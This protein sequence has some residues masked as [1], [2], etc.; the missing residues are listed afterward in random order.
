VDWL[1]ET[2]WANYPFTDEMSIEIGWFYG[3]STVWPEKGEKWHDDCV[4]VKNKRGNVVMCWGMISWNW[5]GLFWV[6]EQQ[7]EEEK[8]N[9]MKAIKVYNINCTVEEKHLNDLWKLSVE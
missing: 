6:W 4:G 5:T 8:W 2:E 7:T 9:A 1:P 3:P